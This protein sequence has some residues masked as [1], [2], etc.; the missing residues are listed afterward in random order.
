[1]GFFY[2]INNIGN[3]I[4]RYFASILGIDKLTDRITVTRK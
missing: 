3:N 4:K 1:M 2:S